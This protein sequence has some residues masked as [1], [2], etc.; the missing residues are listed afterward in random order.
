MV[1][2]HCCTGWD[3][4]HTLPRANMSASGRPCATYDRSRSANALKGSC[5]MIR[6]PE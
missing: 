6:P 5:V 4:F 3:R 1:C 2:A